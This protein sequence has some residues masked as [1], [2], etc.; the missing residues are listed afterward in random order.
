MSRLEWILGGVL[1][2]LLLLIGLVAA[3]LWL[4]PDDP[5]TLADTGF[6]GDTVGFEATSVFAGQTAQIAYATAQ[7]AAVAWQADA[8]LTSAT[9]TWP[10]GAARELMLSGAADWGFTFYSVSASAIAVFS[11][12]GSQAN[13]VTQGAA[14]TQ[15]TAADLGGWQVDS[16]AVATTLLEQG[17]SAFIDQEGLTTL[18]MT[19]S[20]N[21]QAGRIEW[22][23]S[24]VGNQ[25]GNSLNL[26]MNGTT[27]EV[28]EI[29]R[30][31]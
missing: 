24:L 11:V 1:A 9:A 3:F 16:P 23:A 28:I 12:T 22:F 8:L 26:V 4:Q 7:Q 29:A 15:A 21:T 17:G 5:P 18:V 25:T 2:L 31:P 13:L 30:F 6:G 14:E 27:G 19:L 10:Q 20:T